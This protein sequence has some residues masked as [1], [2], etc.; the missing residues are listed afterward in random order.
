MGRAGAG[1]HQSFAGCEVL[2]GSCA[3]LQSGILLALAHQVQVGA[4]GIRMVQ[5]A[6]TLGVGLFLWEGA[7]IVVVLRTKG[8]KVK[9]RTL[10]VLPPFCSPQGSSRSQKGYVHRHVHELGCTVPCPF[11]QCLLWTCSAFLGSD[12][13]LE[14]LWT[15]GKSR[16][17]FHSH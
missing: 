13:G 11:P 5:P 16:V 15:V 4:D 10:I 8:G 3:G 6:A 1:P 9:I 7:V 12:P 2:Q 17:C 14:L